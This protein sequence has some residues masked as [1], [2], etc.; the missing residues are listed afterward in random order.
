MQDS[1][2]SDSSTK[3]S[4]QT[5]RSIRLRLF[6]T[7]G[8]TRSKKKKDGQRNLPRRFSKVRKQELERLLVEFQAGNFLPD[9]F[10][11]RD[12]TKALLEFLCP[13]ISVYLPS[14]KVLGGRILKAHAALCYDLEKKR[15]LNKQATTGGQVNFLSDVW[16]NVSREHLLGC[17]LSLFGSVLTYA[18]PKTGSRH[19]GLAI[20][21]EMEDII[22]LAT[23]DGWNTG[24]IFLF[25]FAHCINNIVKAV[26][27]SAFSTVAKEATAA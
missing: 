21:E 11:E 18:M 10:I 9:I 3:S 5:K 20:A 1:E 23:N 25:C 27:N 15:L 4:G 14:R 22:T 17:Q 13:G 2:D 19:D 8:S 12:C 24:M 6:S 26:L 7:G 16:Q